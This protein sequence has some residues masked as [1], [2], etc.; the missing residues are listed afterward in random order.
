MILI[1]IA[2]PYRAE[3]QSAVEANIQRARTVGAEL[4]FQS[5]MC[6]EEPLSVFPVIPHANTG[7]FDFETLIK[8]VP[9]EYY[10][11]GTMEML[12]RCGAVILTSWDAAQGSAGTIQEIRYANRN[13]IPVFASVAAFICYETDLNY[14]AEVEKAIRQHSDEIY[15]GEKNFC[16][17]EAYPLIIFGTSKDAEAQNEQITQPSQ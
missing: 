10:L 1:Y 8:D 3:T 15:D 4:V 2:G 5:Q 9:G 11:D 12:K 7:L 13:A 17:P 6:L 16:D 14:Q